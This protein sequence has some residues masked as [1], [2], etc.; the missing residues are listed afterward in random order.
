MYLP[1]KASQLNKYRRRQ[2]T[3]QL[4]RPFPSNHN[5]WG[6]MLL[7]KKRKR[8]RRYEHANIQPKVTIK[9]TYFL[10]VVLEQHI[11]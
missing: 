10:Q 2:M 11:V 5:M 6:S 7:G 3:A 8:K 9:V 4:V 1:S